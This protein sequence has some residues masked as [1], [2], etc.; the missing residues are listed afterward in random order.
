MGAWGGAAL[1][2]PGGVSKQGWTCDPEHADTARTCAVGLAWRGEETAL[3]TVLLEVFHPGS[4]ATGGVA[5]AATSN[6]SSA[7]VCT[8]PRML[9]V[10]VSVTGLS[11]PLRIAGQ[12][13]CGQRLDN[14]RLFRATPSAPPQ[15]G[16]Q[17]T[18]SACVHGVRCGGR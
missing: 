12:R 6:H 11:A 8:H 10:T 13:F 7:T 1:R 16:T 4:A 18:A 5:E 3:P 9:S 2:E 15:P 17:R 14:V